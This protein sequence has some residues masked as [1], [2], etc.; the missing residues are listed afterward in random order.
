[1][2]GIGRSRIE[3]EDARRTE[4]AR[5]RLVSSGVAR[6]EEKV[7]IVEPAPGQLLV[8]ARGAGCNGDDMQVIPESNRVPCSF[9]LLDEFAPGIAAVDAQCHRPRLLQ[10]EPD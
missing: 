3:V 7:V 5:C 6:L 10:S 4:M 8:S 9:K 1:M 2:Q